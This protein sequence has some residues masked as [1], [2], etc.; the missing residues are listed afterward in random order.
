MGQG[1]GVPTHVRGPSRTAAHIAPHRSRRQLSWKNQKSRS[2][3]GISEV[4]DTGFE[5]VTPSLSS[6][7]RMSQPCGFQAIW[8]SF[9]DSLTEVVRYSPH[10][11]GALGTAYLV[12]ATVT[13]RHSSRANV[14]RGRHREAPP[15]GTA[16]EVATG[17]VTEP[18]M[19]GTERRVPGLPEARR[20]H[21]P[22]PRAASG[23]RQLP[24][25]QASQRHRL[26]RQASAR[27]DASHADL[28]FLETDQ[29]SKEYL[30]EAEI[31][32]VGAGFPDEVI[33]IEGRGI[34]RNIDARRQAC[35]NGQIGRAVDASDDSRCLGRASALGVTW[36]WLA[37]RACRPP[38]RGSGR[39]SCRR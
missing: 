11:R 38:R 4:G 23:G 37:S 36:V 27:A 1:S 12:C 17:R 13:R 19:S 9:W 25:G 22:A 18:A 3:S 6:W 31:P 8:D 2:L 15:G 34:E 35:G 24:D 32:L 29:S 10:V 5:P 14:Q 26:A 28:G 33:G 21:L 20:A 30:K 16:L 39:T 7:G